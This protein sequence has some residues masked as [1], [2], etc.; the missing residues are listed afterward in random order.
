MSDIEFINGLMAKQP[1]ENAPSFVKASISIKREDLIAWLSARN[2]EWINA[3]IKE[4]RGG[5]WYVSV[6]DR[7][8]RTASINQ[9]H[10][11]ATENNDL[12]S[13]EIPF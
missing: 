12:D 8:A 10:R 3:D 6:N 13:S 11:S 4:S 7:K 5:K 1:N 9:Q 2:D